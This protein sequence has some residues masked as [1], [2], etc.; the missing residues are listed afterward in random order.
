MW[1]S[2]CGPW[3]TVFSDYSSWRQK[4]R[5]F[6]WR[7]HMY[8]RNHNLAVRTDGNS[9]SHSLNFFL[10]QI[11]LLGTVLISSWSPQLMYSLLSNRI[12]ADLVTRKEPSIEGREGRNASRTTEHLQ[13]RFPRNY[14]SRIFWGPWTAS[15]LFFTVAYSK[16]QNVDSFRNCE[17]I[18]LKFSTL[19]DVRC[20]TLGNQIQNGNGVGVRSCS[21]P[22]A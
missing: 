1:V 10:A 7:P 17:P 14:W 20:V 3:F 19:F 13:M 4:E 8:T 22:Y 5:C 16:N 18:S 12:V 11:W 6:L 21:L 9:F 15:Q 2:M